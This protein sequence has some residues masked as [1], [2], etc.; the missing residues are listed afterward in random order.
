LGARYPGLIVAGTHDGYFD[1]DRAAEVADEIRASGA[2]L[3]FAG[4]GSPRQEFWLA[5]H[6]SETGCSAGIGVGGSFDVIS[7]RIERAPRFLRRLG[8]EWLY[9]LIKEPHRWRRQLALAQFLWLV[10]L[11]AI[12][13][14]FKRAT[15]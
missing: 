6:L 14:R 3:L 8:L 12:G 9:R 5:D 7:G 2:R 4:L 13:F 10:T 15:T 1:P 11:E